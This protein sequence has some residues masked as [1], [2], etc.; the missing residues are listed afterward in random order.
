MRGLCRTGKVYLVGA[1]PGARDLLTLRALEV[2]RKAD[3][4]VYDHLVS[5]DV[6][7]YIPYFTRRIF[8]G[9]MKSYHTRTQGRINSLLGRYALEGYVVVRLKGGDPLLFGRAGEELGYLRDRGVMVEIVPGITAASGCA[10]EAGFSLTDRVYGTA[11]TFITGHSRDGF[12]YHNWA[13][14][15]ASGHTLVIYMG[16]TVAARIAQ[17]LIDAGLQETVP[18]VV[19][20]KGTRREQRIIY[21]ILSDLAI[22]TVTV[23][24]TGPALI[25]I[26]RVVTNRSRGRDTDVFNT[27]QKEEDDVLNTVQK[28]E[29]IV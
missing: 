2:L 18:I 27:V 7:G 12:A 24:L 1:G 8:V 16:L 19:I 13:T 29:E 23:G 22:G 3:I 10:A 15:A 6:L 21:G 26:G 14:L 25:V 5:E 20:D 28:E 11:I 17:N 9:K 4:V